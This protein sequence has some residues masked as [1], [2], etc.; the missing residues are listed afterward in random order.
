MLYE[1]SQQTDERFM[2]MALAEA[3]DAASRGEVPVGAVIECGGRVIARTSNMTQQLRDVSAHAEMLAITSAA[4]NLGG[5]YLTDCTLYVTVEP[6]IMCAGAL[7]WS[8]I[9]RIVYGASDPKRGYASWFASEKS[10]LHPRTKVTS[11]VLEDECAA[12][13]QDFFKSRRRRP[14]NP[15][16]D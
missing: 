11:G 2:R 8:Q 16:S 3:A 12:L 10:P 15:H 1:T 9:G 4:E 5:K 13:M 7:G 6:C 14:A